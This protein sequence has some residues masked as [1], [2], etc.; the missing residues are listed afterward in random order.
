[1]LAVPLWPVRGDYSVL[2]SADGKPVSG[3]VAN[4]DLEIVESKTPNLPRSFRIDTGAAC[5]ATSLKRAEKLGLLRDDDREVDLKTRTPSE[6][7]AVRRVRIGTLVARI[8][9]LR[10]EP[11][12]WPIVFHPEW[13]EDSPL[14]LGLLGV[15][16][17]L[18]IHIDGTPNPMSEFGSVTLTLRRPSAQPLD[19]QP[20]VQ[21]VGPQPP[22]S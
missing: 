16:N 14:L 10:P 20:P 2:P 6:K 22:T 3:L 19:A 4:V 7:R 17:D 18:T 1:M 8:P 21:E 11:F 13:P 9:R 5:S 15:T 12:T